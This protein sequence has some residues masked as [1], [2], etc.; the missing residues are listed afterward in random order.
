MKVVSL[1]IAGGVGKRLWPK[2]DTSCPKQFSDIFNCGKSLLEDSVYRI[3]SLSKEEDTFIITDKRF[4]ALI[5]KLNLSI[6]SENIFYEPFGRNTLPA[7]NFSIEM[8][9]RKYKEDVV[10]LVFPCDHRIDNIKLFKESVERAIETSIKYDSIVTIGISPSSPNTN[11]GYIKQ[12]EMITNH[13]FKVDSFKE[14]PSL[15]LAQEYIQSNKYLWNSGIFI[16]PLNTMMD[17]IKKHASEQQKLF[18]QYD[19]TSISNKNNLKDIYSKLSSISIDKGLIEKCDKLYVVKA[20]FEW[21]DL[22]TWSSIE[23]YYSRNENN[24]ISTDSK[25]VVINKCKN[26]SVLSYDSNDIIVSGLEDVLVI[27]SNNKLL[28]IKKSDIANIPSLVDEL[29]KKNNLD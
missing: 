3:S 11:Y 16:F 9:K 24:N 29:E 28:I 26:T 25:H 19:P 6:P 2:S 13:L 5:N 17:E 7:I 18:E 27:S 20:E 14:K 10:V 1:F 15:E 4:A 8:I 23:K 22:G 12:G 21:D